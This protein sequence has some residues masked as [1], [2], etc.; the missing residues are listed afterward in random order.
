M[1]AGRTEVNTF[2][3]LGTGSGSSPNNA[4]KIKGNGAVAME[5]GG[6]LR[7]VGQFDSLACGF[8]PRSD[9][10]PD[11]GQIA[12]ADITERPTKELAKNLRNHW[13]SLVLI[14]I[15]AEDNRMGL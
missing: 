5:I 4:G 8:T 11:V 15:V 7:P 9:S 13:D 6:I 14:C 2:R 10:L 3:W 12:F 1:A